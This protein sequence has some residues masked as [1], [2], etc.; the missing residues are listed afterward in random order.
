LNR[1]GDCKIFSFTDI[2]TKKSQA[3]NLHAIY[4]TLIV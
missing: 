2:H 4:E 3:N 1:I